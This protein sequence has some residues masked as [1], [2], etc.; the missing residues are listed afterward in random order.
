MASNFLVCIL[1]A[2]ALLTAAPAAAAKCQLSRILELPVRMEGLRPMID[3]T[4]NGKAARFLVDSGAFYSL[5]TPAAAERLDLK[6][7]PLTGVRLQGVGG[8]ERIGVTKVKAMMLGK[9]PIAN[10]EFAVGGRN[11]GGDGSDGV[12]GQNILGATDV[13]YDLA[14]GA[15]RLF[16]AKDCKDMGLAYWSKPGEASVMKIEFAT[17]QQPHIVGKAQVNGK[18]ISVMFDTGASTSVLTLDAAERVGAGIGTPGVTAGGVVQGFGRGYV[19]SWIVPVSSFAIAQEEIRNTRLRVSRMELSE[20]MLL[21]ADFFLSHR[22]YI[23]RSQNLVYFTY[24]GGPVFRLDRN[25]SRVADAEDAEAAP[26]LKD[27]SA[28]SRRAAASMTR[29]DYRSAVADL[30][31]AIALEPQAAGHYRDRGSA[32]I[33]AGDPA[34][35]LADFDKAI[36]LDPADSRALT[37]RGQ[38]YLASKDMARARAD[39][40]AAA[41]AASNDAR[42]RLTIATLYSQAGYPSEAVAELDDWIGKNPK[43]PSM[44]QALNARCW[45]RAVAGR[46]LDLALADCEAALR[47]GRNSNVLDSRGLVRLRRGELKAAIADYD[48]VLKLQPKAPWSL[49]GR[50]LAKVLSGDRAGGE[51][52]M[53]AGLA[54]DST[55]AE[56][57]ERYGL[58]EKKVRS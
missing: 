58:T 9:A 5:M 22:V 15:L 51:A 21:G 32:H 44:P 56:Q 26:E 13:E 29:R 3:V 24:N 33:G 55:L 19:E 2:V 34:K 57:V 31:A 1:A 48:A 38:G 8:T 17:A 25:P 42:V 12:I 52:D 40:T 6:V 47:Y 37:L 43:H 46:E 35:A 10:I 18:P 36:A 41:K 20:D 45:T 4:I 11:L 28:L 27:A 14:N 23:A 39:F 16:T 50:G 54:L 49:Y 30:T 7:S 53:K